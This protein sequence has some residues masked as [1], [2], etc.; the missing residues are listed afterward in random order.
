[1]GGADATGFS[2]DN[3]HTAQF[4]ILSV[5]AH[6][7]HRCLL[8]FNQFPFRLAR[9]CDPHVEVEDKHQL[10][11]DFLS[12]CPCCLDSGY[13]Q[14]LKAYMEA[15]RLYKQIKNYR[16]QTICDPDFS[17]FS[18]ANCCE[19]VPIHWTHTQMHEIDGDL[20]GP[21]SSCNGSASKWGFAFR[22][23]NLRLVAALVTKCCLGVISHEVKVFSMRKVTNAE[24][25]CNFGRAVSERLLGA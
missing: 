14:R 6:I 4:S 23:S 21:Q 2:I 22:G 7:W 18:I 24:I 5:C 1:M 11:Q 3:L 8:P 20:I 9:L 13:S 12:A 16:L 25:E 19:P 10:A 17:F 15:S